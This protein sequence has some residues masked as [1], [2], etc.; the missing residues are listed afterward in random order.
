VCCYKKDKTRHYGII[1]KFCFSPPLALITP[2]K[3]TSSSLLGRAG[4]PCRENLQ[5]YAEVDLL[6]AFIVEVNNDLLPPS[7]IPISSLLSKCVKVSCKD[8]L[9][10][11]IVHIPNNYEH[12]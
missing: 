12:H 10:S 8:S 2:F 1:Q 3:Q 11:Y 9:H 5:T 6:G 7:A 4:N